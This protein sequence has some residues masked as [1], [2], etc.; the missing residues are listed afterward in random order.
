VD[1]YST[2]QAKIAYGIR[3]ASQAL[4]LGRTTVFDLIAAGKLEAYKC[5]GRTLISADS[6]RAFLASLPR[7][8]TKQGFPS[9]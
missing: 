3:S 4:D 6:L 2:A 1:D 7:V 8:Q 9:N 5:G